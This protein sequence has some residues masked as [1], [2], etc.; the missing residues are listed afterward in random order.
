MS[1]I[2]PDMI[3]FALYSANQAMQRVYAPLLQKLG[4]TYP[5]YLVMLSLWQT[6]GQTV[7]DLGRALG[8]ESNT[9]TPLLK[10]MEAQGLI[11]RSR[12][13]ADERQ[14]RI[15]LTDHGRGLQAGAQPLTACIVEACG[16]PPEDIADL[17]DRITALRDRLRQAG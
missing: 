12:D 3:C 4:L 9:V 16:M 11:R 13:G 2:L 10:R 5:Q 1:P 14:V 15:A 8:L 7:G 17:R 6:D